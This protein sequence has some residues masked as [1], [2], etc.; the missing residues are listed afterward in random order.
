MK[1]YRKLR[2]KPSIAELVARR[3]KREA[4]VTKATFDATE[5]TTNSPKPDPLP[6]P[7]EQKEGTK[8]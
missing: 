8:P 4:I 2:I 7:A 3:M 5:D 6:A 1:G